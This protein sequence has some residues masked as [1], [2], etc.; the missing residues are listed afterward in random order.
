MMK[1]SKKVTPILLASCAALLLAVP[2]FASTGTSSD[3][4]VTALGP[5]DGVKIV[6]VIGSVQGT[7]GVLTSS[8]KIE[9]NMSVYV[10]GVLKTTVQLR[11]GTDNPGL[12]NSTFTASVGQTVSA[13]LQ[14]WIKENFSAIYYTSDSDSLTL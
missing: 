11:N 9:G 8:Q 4:N 5:N 3:V 14:G 12:L 2:A 13:N 7:G 6:N 10:G 1:I